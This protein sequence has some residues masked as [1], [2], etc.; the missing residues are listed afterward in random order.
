MISYD[1]HIYSMQRLEQWGLVVST[2]DEVAWINGLMNDYLT[3]GLEVLRRVSQGC[4]SRFRFPRRSFCDG[5]YASLGYTWVSRLFDMSMGDWGV[6]K[7][8]C[9]YLWTGTIILGLLRC[10]LLCDVSVGT[11][12]MSFWKDSERHLI[13]RWY[14][15]AMAI[16]HDYASD[17]DENSTLWWQILRDLRYEWRFVFC[18]KEG[19]HAKGRSYKLS[20]WCLDDR[21]PKLGRYV[22]LQLDERVKYRQ[23]LSGRY[24]RSTDSDHLAVLMYGRIIKEDIRA[25][26]AWRRTKDQLSWFGWFSQSCDSLLRDDRESSWRKKAIQ[27]CRGH[28]S[29]K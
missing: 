18:V 7:R 26:P 14:K 17:R 12:E 23:R 5:W 6:I 3:S 8:Q 19:W 11:I 21:L 20:L 28:S 10:A 22:T 4:R 15:I 13:L 27:T 16:W 9:S 24:D 1:S 2:L 25:T 29:S